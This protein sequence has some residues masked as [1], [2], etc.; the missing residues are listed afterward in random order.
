MLSSLK[1]F[2]VHLS[3]FFLWIPILTFSQ[4]PKLKFKHI[5]N[6]QGLSNSTIESIYQDHR[7]FIWFATRD[8]LNRYD[9]YKTVVY[10]YDP[11]DSS[12]ISDN[13]IRYIYEDKNDGLW[14]GTN[15]GLN[16]FDMSKNNFTRYKHNPNDPNSLSNNIVNCIYEDHNGN[17]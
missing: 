1:Y 13:Y 8:G 12:S 5:T 2:P 14:I 4:A 16:R 11:K 3:L 7:G 17:L 10:R 15:N 9:G 6:E